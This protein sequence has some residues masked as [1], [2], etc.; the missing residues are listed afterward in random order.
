MAGGVAKMAEDAKKM[1]LKTADQVGAELNKGGKIKA[2]G[3]VL[4]KGIEL[5]G[6]AVDAVKN[7]DTYKSAAKKSGEFV[8][9]AKGV[10]NAAKD[11]WKEA[12]ELADG[13]ANKSWAVPPKDKK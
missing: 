8:D 5:G 1:G 4:D 10:W 2:T 7:T 12:K 6:K 9:D 13:L 3:D 11:S